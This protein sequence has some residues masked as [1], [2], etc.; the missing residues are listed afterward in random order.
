MARLRSCSCGQRHRQS[1]IGCPNARKGRQAP[2]VRVVGALLGLGAVFL[3]LSGLPDVT[4]WSG[5]GSAE[6]TT[7][8]VTRVVD[9]DTVVVADKSGRDLGRVRILG[10]DAPETNP[11]QC[12]SKESTQAAKRLL[13]GKDVTLVSD[14]KNDDRDD[15]GRLLRYV[16][17]P[18]GDGKSRDVTAVMLRQGHAW[19]TAKARTHTREADYRAPSK[20]AKAAGRGVW[21]C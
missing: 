13:E 9:G 7:G 1:T 18:G 4:F 2:S 10:M 21:S 8:T 11:A 12:W 3:L 17:L 15:N 6:S 16:D 5:S 19:K 14:P 20:A